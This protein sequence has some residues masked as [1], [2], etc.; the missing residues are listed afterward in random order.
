AEKRDIAVRL[1]GFIGLTPEYILASDLRI[2]PGRFRKELL[3]EQRLTLGRY[4]DRFTGM[5]VDAAGETPEYDPSDTG[6]TGAFVAA[7]HDYLAHELDYTTDLSYRPTYYRSGVQ[8]DFTHRVQG[9]GGGNGSNQADVA[10]DLSQ[11]MRENP[12]LLLYSLN[13]IYDLATPFFGTE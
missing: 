4:D 13:G 3:H 7:F 11:A 1:A 5:D 12:H 10:L 8:W 9:L 2:S 6:I